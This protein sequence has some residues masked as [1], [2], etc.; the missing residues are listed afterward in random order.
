MTIKP[1]ATAA[2]NAR[3]IGL[4]LS[5]LRISASVA[6]IEDVVDGEV[7][8]VRRDAL[9][10]EELLVLDKEHNRLRLCLDA[11]GD[12]LGGQCLHRFFKLVVVLLLLI[13]VVARAD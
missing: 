2:R 10:N 6:D 13:V 11:V 9:V 3:L 7:T 8:H 1:D 12:A 4:L 5:L